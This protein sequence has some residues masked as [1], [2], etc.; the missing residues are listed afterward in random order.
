MVSRRGFLGLGV[1]ATAAITLVACDSSSITSVFSSSPEP[2]AVLRGV[3][4]AL[5]SAAATAKDQGAAG[6][7]K[8]YN[9]QATAINDEVLRQCGVDDE[10]NHPATCTTTDQQGAGG[11]S[12]ASGAAG[13]T[14]ATGT[15]GGSGDSKNSGN[16]SAA[17]DPQ[18]AYLDAIALNQKD[19]PDLSADEYTTQVSILTGLYAAFTTSQDAA[20]MKGL[21]D[22]DVEKVGEST[23]ST[24]NITALLRLTY[25]AIYAS[26]LVL[27]ADG[28]AHR[29]VLATITT[30]L[31]ELR[32]DLIDM[33]NANKAAVPE[34]EPGY[35]PMEGQQAPSNPSQAAS[36]YHAALLP[37]TAG[38]RQLSSQAPTAEGRVLFARWCGINARGEAALESILGEDPLSVISRG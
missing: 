38:L 7:E 25:S 28:G 8:F 6:L 32:D 30:R 5:Q 21:E 27:A 33:L 26:G 11:T 4:A 10:G 24:D 13:S 19:Q 9:A 18:T 2:N 35:R 15:A 29:A 14:D 36:F 34:P 23:K 37:I 31:R 1:T 12:G 17:K 16:N 20:D 3:E 22:I